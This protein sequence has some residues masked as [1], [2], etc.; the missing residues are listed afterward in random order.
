[1]IAPM[2]VHS[3]D[4]KTPAFLRMRVGSSKQIKTLKD[5]L[6]NYWLEDKK[7][8]LKGKEELKYET[9][10][11]RTIVVQNLPVHFKNKQLIE[12][13]SSYGSLASIELPVK[14]L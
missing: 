6:R 7:M 12:H 11:H 4:G 9:F 14:N 1:M 13:F 2:L 3:L 5:K 10:E 8:K